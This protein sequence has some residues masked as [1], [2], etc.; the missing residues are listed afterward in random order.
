MH[1]ILCGP[2]Y[3]E[4]FI[5]L[6]LKMSAGHPNLFHMR[7]E[8]RFK[9]IGIYKVYDMAQFVW[10]QRMKALHIQFVKFV[11]DLMYLTHVFVFVWSFCLCR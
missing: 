3:H 9:Y 4:L 5:K 1:F 11:S 2:F 8:C 7:D 6:F 10:D